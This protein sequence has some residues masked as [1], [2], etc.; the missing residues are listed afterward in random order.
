MDE[1]Y[2][3][4]YIKEIIIVRIDNEIIYFSMIKI[5]NQNIRIISM[6]KSST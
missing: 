1:I 2:L 5:W 4:A 6:T 3:I